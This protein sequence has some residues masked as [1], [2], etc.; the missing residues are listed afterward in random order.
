[1][2]ISDPSLASGYVDKDGRSVLFDD[3]GELF[4]DLKA[5]PS[6]RGISYVHDASDDAWIKAESA[7]FVRV[8]GLQTPMG[9]GVIAFRDVAASREWQRR[10][11]KPTTACSNLAEELAS[12]E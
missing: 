11:S 7:C 10:Y 5:N 1:M 8:S 6:L 9:S 12:P 2:I 3:L 4:A